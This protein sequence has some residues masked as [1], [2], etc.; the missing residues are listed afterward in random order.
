M[1]DKEIELEETEASYTPGG[2]GQSRVQVS[3]KWR[4]CRRYST[5]M[6]TIMNRSHRSRHICEGSV[7]N[8]TYEP[9]RMGERGAWAWA[10]CWCACYS[11]LSDVL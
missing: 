10:G 9:V 5:V 6:C 7:A 1:E 11:T 8:K 3:G 4:G 2:A